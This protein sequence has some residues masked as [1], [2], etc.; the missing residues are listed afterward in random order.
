MYVDYQASVVF[1]KLAI[2]NGARPIKRHDEKSR[3]QH[4]PAHCAKNIDESSFTRI[5]AGFASVTKKQFVSEGAVVAITPA[6]RS[7]WTILVCPRNRTLVGSALATIDRADSS[8]Q[9]P[10]CSHARDC[11]YATAMPRERLLGQ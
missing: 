6:P 9:G 4:Q 7:A 5:K 8:D 2:E 10:I 11:Q 3:G 1:R